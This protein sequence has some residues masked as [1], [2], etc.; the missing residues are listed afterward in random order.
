MS[1]QFRVSWEMWPHERPAPAPVSRVYDDEAEARD[2]LAGLRRIQASHEP[3]PCG[4]HVWN[5]RFEVRE[6]HEWRT[7]DA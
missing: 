2:H 4:D 3:R 7:A 1:K 6:S 5:V